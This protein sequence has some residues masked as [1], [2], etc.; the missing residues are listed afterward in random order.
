MQNFNE[1]YSKWPTNFLVDKLYDLQNETYT[2][3]NQYRIVAI[4]SIL[5]SR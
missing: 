5:K 2:T 3:I 1:I 4:Q